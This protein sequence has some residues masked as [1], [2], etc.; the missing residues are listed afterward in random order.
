MLLTRV[1]LPTQGPPVMTATLCC[2]KRISDAT[3]APLIIS[4]G[5]QLIVWT[6]KSW[7]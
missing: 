6:I 5:S 2:C 3:I 1:V 4:C 7:S